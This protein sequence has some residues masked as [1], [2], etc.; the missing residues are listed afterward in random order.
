MQSPLLTFEQVKKIPIVEFLSSN[1][2]EPVKIRGVDYWYH[3][4]LHADNTPSF[5]VN[6]KLNVWYDHGIGQ[7]GTILDLGAELNKISPNEF[8][9]RISQQHS[10]FPQI[11]NASLQEKENNKL[12]IIS[13]GPLSSPGLM[14]YLGSRGINRELADEFCKQVEFRIGKKNYSA[15]GFQNRSGGYELRNSWF[16]GAS[17][18][19]DISIIIGGNENVCLLEGFFDFLSLVKFDRHFQKIVR[20][21]SSFVILNSL[22]LMPRSLEIISQY[23]STQLFLDNDSAAIKAKQQLLDQKNLLITDE[24]K[25]YAASK[26]MNDFLLTNVANQRQRVKGKSRNL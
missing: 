6:T 21:N 22:S 8:R 15:I 9:K 26:D 2:I 24:S 18:P 12:E 1:G 4:P 10:I 13:T 5:K 23:P 7:G 17:S 11:T 16:K 3:S 19:K 20:P 14:A 25:L